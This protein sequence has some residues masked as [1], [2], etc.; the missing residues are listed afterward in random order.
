MKS[1]MSIY[2][3]EEGDFLEIMFGEP[4]SDYGDHVSKDIVLF[5]NQET[6]KII[7]VGI[8]NFKQH[9]KELSNLKLD[10]PVEVNL[11]ALKV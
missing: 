9:T 8:F 7:G 2:Y 1:Q 5:R 4:I 11:S 10:L 6:D 3:D